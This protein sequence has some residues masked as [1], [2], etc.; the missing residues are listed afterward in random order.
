MA[1]L[2]QITILNDFVQYLFTYFVQLFNFIMQHWLLFVPF[3]LVLLDKI[4]INVK[5]ITGR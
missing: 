4:Y 3:A 5:K 2:N 1:A